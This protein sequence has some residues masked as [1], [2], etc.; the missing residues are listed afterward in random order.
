[1]KRLLFVMLT[2]VLVLPLA[3]QGR[4]E[5]VWAIQV[6]DDEATDELSVKMTGRDTIIFETGGTYSQRTTVT[7]TLVMPG[8]DAENPVSFVIAARAPGQWNRAGALLSLAPDK[9]KAEAEVSGT[10]LSGILRMMLVNPIRKEMLKELKR[11]GSYR[12]V[13]LSD[14][15]LKLAGPAG[16]Q[17]T[18]HRV[19]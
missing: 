17:E 7:V 3:A 8:G 12:I 10:G 18:Y 19:E 2:G 15:E 9:K 1:M 16:S 14:S 4:L 5:G 13:L 6:E 11:G